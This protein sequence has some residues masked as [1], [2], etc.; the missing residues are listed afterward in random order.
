MKGSRVFN[1]ILRDGRLC[2]QDIQSFNSEATQHYLFL[3]LILS[4]HA[5]LQTISQFVILVWKKI[6]LIYIITCMRNVLSFPRGKH[7]GLPL[8][9]ICGNCF[10]PL[11]Y[12]IKCCLDLTYLWLQVVLSVVFQRIFDSCSSGFF[13]LLYVDEYFGHLYNDFQC[14]LHSMK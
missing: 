6:Q 3:S 7:K 1:T 13:P 2:R 5:T 4:S 11:R 12:W 14:H 9:P 8:F 10:W